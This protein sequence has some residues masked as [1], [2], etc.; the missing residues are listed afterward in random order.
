MNNTTHILI[1]DDDQGIRELLC[2]FLQQHGF[3]VYAAKNGDQMRANLKAHP[4]D[5]IILD[6]MMPGDDGMTLCKAVRQ[7]SQIPIIMLT[8]VTEDIEHILALEIGAD[9]FITKPFNPRTLLARIKAVLRRAQGEQDVSTE[10]EE[11][12]GRH[13]RFSGWLLDTTTRRLT[14]PD[15][16]EISLSSGE[17]ALLQIFV[18]HPEH[19][20]SR[21]FLLDTT[22]HRA[23]SPYDRSIDIQISRLRQKIETDPKNPQLIKTVR[24][25]GY[26]LAST[27]LR[28]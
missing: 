4:I 6:I 26:V 8:A 14:S 17:Y 15:E 21:D 1:V 11:T 19:V 13:Y 5:L 24:G 23:A 16:L 27:V 12:K 25:G 9:D 10:E 28:S 3:E 22:K 20:L 2:D 7:T 18:D